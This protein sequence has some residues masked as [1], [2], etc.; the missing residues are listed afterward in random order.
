MPRDRSIRKVL[1]IGSGPIVI[2]QAAEFDYSGSQCCKSLR[3]EGVEVVLVNSNPATI[4]TDPEIADSVY[5]E[6]LTV[7]FVA[8]IIRKERPD[9]LIATMGGQTGLN[10][11][12]ELGELGVLEAERVRVLGTG[13][14]SI[15]M[16][17]DREEFKVL[18]EKI[19]EP[20]LRSRNVGGVEGAVEFAR[21]VGYPLIVRPA[22]TLGGS[23]GGTARDEEELRRIVSR[24][25]RMSR[26]DQALVEESVIGWGEFEW[27]VMRDASGTCISIC[28]MENIDPMGIHTGESAVVAPVLT[29]SDDDL[30]KLRSAALHIIREL[31]IEGGCNVQFAFDYA[32]GEYK[33]IEVNPRVSRSSALASKATGYPIAKISTKIALGYRLHELR[34]DVTGTSACFEPALDYVVVKVPRWPFEKFR[35]V[36]RRLGTEMRSTGEVMAIGRTLE[37]ALQKALRSLETGRAGIGEDGRELPWDE[38]GLEEPND[39]RLFHVYEALKGGLPPERVA[40]LTRINLFFINKIHNILKEADRLRG[41]ELG[42]LGA[43]ELRRA[44]ANGFSDLQL[45]HL[46]GSSEA[47]VRGRRT[48]LGVTPSYKLVDTCAAEFEAVTPYFY[49]TYDLENEA[50]ASDRRKVLVI[51]AG[52]NRIGQGV[53]FDYCCSHASIALREAGYESIMVNCNPETV[54]TDY[55]MS[56]RLYFEPLT[57]ED[58]LN[59]VE[60]ERPDGVIVQFGGQTSINLAVKLHEAGVPVL[61]TPPGSIDRAEDR[62][63]WTHVLQKLGIPQPDF[64]TGYSFEEVRDIARDIGYP[65]LVRPSYVL[66]GR[67]MEVVWDEDELREY[68]KLAAEVSPDHPVLV[69]KFLTDAIEAETDAVCDGRNVVVGAFMEHIQQAGVHSGDAASV[70][71]PVSLDDETIALMRDYT[72]AIALELGVVGLVNVQFAIKDGEVY[73]IEANP[74]ASRTVPYVSKGTGKPLAKIATKAMLGH[75]LPELGLSGEVAPDHFSVKEAVLPFLKMPGFDPVLGPEMRSTGEVMGVGRTFGEAFYKAEAGAGTV[76]PSAGSG[77]RVVLSIADQ[78]KERMLPIASRL[79]AAGLKLVGTRGTAR[80][81]E[82]NGVEC[83]TVGKVGESEPNILT[84]LQEG[85][86]LVVCTPEAGRRDREEGALIRKSAVELGISFLSTVEAAG[87]ALSA[88]ESASHGGTSVASLSELHEAISRLPRRRRPGGAFLPRSKFF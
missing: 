5:I 47:E 80:H 51:G 62:E 75:K 34:N 11:T 48:E 41:R 30:Q 1:V 6:P 24:G 32:T 60:Q 44:K 84:V 15:R 65:V 55:D 74:R 31:G 19:G 57:F 8:E 81:L 37:E 86:E 27:E 13:L 25:L 85:T 40:G 9:G 64:G 56:S 78:D 23:G 52:P 36:P 17:E 87:A 76:L 7:G 10:L 49:S 58:V 67:A 72:S 26:I 43:G 33:V 73:V 28:S 14:E 69:D 18:M 22:F 77:A 54:S 20:V 16:A 21:E 79:A 2:G 45:A 66:G 61:G 35:G 63:K 82:K 38:D 42:E 53:E 4:M 3:E 46:T 70:F 59:V 88:I 39:L 50:R 83:E 71:P 12:T 68:M 29:L